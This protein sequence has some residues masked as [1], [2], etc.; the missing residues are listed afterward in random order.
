[1]LKCKHLTKCWTAENIF[2]GKIGYIVLSRRNLPISG[3]NLPTKNVQ[4]PYLGLRMYHMYEKPDLR[5]N[6]NGYVIYIQG[7][8]QWTENG[9]LRDTR[10]NR[11]PVRFNT[12][13]YYPLLPEAQKSI[14]P[15]QCLSTY[16]ITKQFAFKKFMWK[17]VRDLEDA[18]FGVPGRE[19]LDSDA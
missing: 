9:A 2:R 4:S 15:F 7:E 16:T 10:H 12:I 3:L 1:M 14:Y 8:Q 13:N 18:R 19:N 5:V 17:G 6:A 11:G